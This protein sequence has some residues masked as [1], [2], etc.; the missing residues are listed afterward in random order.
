MTEP[1]AVELISNTLKLGQVLDLADGLTVTETEYEPPYAAI[2]V[3]M[4]DG[5]RWV[6]RVERAVDDAGITGTRSDDDE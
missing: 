1:E 5:S 2:H 6:V 3:Q 4:G